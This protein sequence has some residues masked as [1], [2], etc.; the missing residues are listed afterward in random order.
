MTDYNNQPTN[1]PR[2]DR[3]DQQ[4]CDQFETD[5]D[6]FDGE[7]ADS[8][9]A[10]DDDIG[11]GTE[12]EDELEECGFDDDDN[13]IIEDDRPSPSSVQD[14]VRVFIS[15][16][17]LLRQALDSI[18]F[19]LAPVVDS[20]EA[21]IILIAGHFM[22]IDGESFEEV[23][24][25]A[26]LKTNIRKVLES[27]PPTCPDTALAIANDMLED[28][29]I[30]DTAS[31][32]G[33]S[34]PDR[35]NIIK[36]FVF[37][38][39]MSFVSTDLHDP[40]TVDSTVAT[41]RDELE[42]VSDLGRIEASRVVDPRDEFQPFP[43]DLLPEPVV[44]FVREVAASKLCDPAMVAVPVLATLGSAIGTTRQ[45]RP[46]SDWPEYPILWATVIAESG[47]GKTPVFNA[48]NAPLRELQRAAD[49]EYQERFRLYKRRLRDW[50]RGNTS[51]DGDGGRRSFMPEEPVY[52]HIFTTDT[53]VEAMA[54][55]LS[56]SPRGVLAMKDELSD[57]LGN[58]NAYK[59]AANDG[60][61]YL[62]W[63]G[64]ISS[65]IDRKTQAPIFIERAAVWITGTIQ[66]AVFWRCFPESFTENGF[67]ARFLICY[68]PSTDGGWSNET[69][70]T[71]TAE[72]W[73][74]LLVAL[75]ALEFDQI[76][77]GE[78]DESRTPVVLEITNEARELM[79][80]FCDCNDLEIREEQDVA[81]RTAWQKM[82]GYAAKFAL[83]DHVVRQVL[84]NGQSQLNERNNTDNGVIENCRQPVGVESVQRGIDLAEW[85]KHEARRIYR[86]RTEMASTSNEERAKLI[87][88]VERKGGEVT[89][90]DVAGNFRWLNKN[91]KLAKE[92][93]DELV[94]EGLGYW[95]EK[96][97][98][99]GGRPATYFI[100]R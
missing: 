27:P 18:E 81:T 2:D 52:N 96:T 71:S 49:R 45:I 10:L 72:D 83:I 56:M 69:V 11:T 64:G 21:A 54:K 1:N 59:R 23:G 60:A 43:I 98:A 53:T 40:G 86:L 51:S 25:R 74:N 77:H 3:N 47:I 99:S 5:D 44:T 87:Q 85:F 35:L 26:R 58:L 73:A 8:T 22:L 39:R 70:S 55:M 61:K 75:R 100:L 76:E 48:I 46:K 29:S 93:L 33:I 28:G 41:I 15:D 62:E 68:P 91:S 89:A 7:S 67:L 31:A 37:N 34:Q 97:K 65:K 88:F 20:D 66:P 16:P 84:A 79:A 95:Q 4:T 80:Q 24:F 17:N 92:Y 6:E 12:E 94:T 38:N 36:M 19:D 14:V 90:R 30:I 82:K 57:L 78:F 42:I 50:E 13:V 9:P 63:F 32:E